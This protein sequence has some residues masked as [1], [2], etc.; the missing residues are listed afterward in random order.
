MMTAEAIMTNDEERERYLAERRA[1][2]EAEIRAKGPQTIADLHC[3]GI[4][5]DEEVDEFNAEIEAR[6]AQ[7]R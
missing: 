5:T 1:K 3:S 4:V 2:L 7:Y 6:R